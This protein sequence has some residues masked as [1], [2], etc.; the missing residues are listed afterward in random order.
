MDLPNFP[1]IEVAKS[2]DEI[3][4]N[5]LLET[6][7]Q[8]FITQQVMEHY[9]SFPDLLKYLVSLYSIDGRNRANEIIL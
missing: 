1:I 8:Q 6:F 2:D 4:E 9:T 5:P 7:L 3:V